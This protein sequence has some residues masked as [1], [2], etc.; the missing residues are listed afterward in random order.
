MSA[1][2][3]HP[4]GEKSEPELSELPMPGNS[5]ESVAWLTALSRNPRVAPLLCLGGG[6]LALM[7]VTLVGMPP[8]A[9]LFAAVIAAWPIGWALFAVGGKPLI[10][11]TCRPFAR[12]TTLA[13]LPG[14]RVLAIG[15][16][17]GVLA[18][19]AGTYA[20]LAFSDLLDQQSVDPN[21]ETRAEA[22][23]GGAGLAEQ[24]RFL[25][26]LCL[27]APFAE[28][29]WIRG[30]AQTALVRGLSTYVARWVGALAAVV[31]AAVAFGFMHDYSLPAQLGVGVCGLFYGLAREV[32]RSVWAAIVAHSI[33]NIAVT[34]TILD[35][36]ALPT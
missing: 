21:G 28:E 11:A 23:R 20:D 33:C 26:L 7:A 15:V 24:A 16:A 30:L 3:A 12:F 1:D 9:V 35:L 13:P 31:V 34:L 27:A 22:V 18:V 17:F 4:A 10:R 19:I 6:T 2:D 25:I 36:I 32:A 8:I 29:V 5:A 14:R